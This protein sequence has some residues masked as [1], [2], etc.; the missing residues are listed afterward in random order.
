MDTQIVAIYCICDDILKGL[1]HVEDKQRKMSDAEVLTTS[2]HFV[3]SM[4]VGN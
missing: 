4:C 2:M 3:K 1:H